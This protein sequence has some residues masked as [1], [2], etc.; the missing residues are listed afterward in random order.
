[1][2]ACLAERIN[3]PSSGDGTGTEMTAGESSRERLARRTGLAIRTIL[4]S[5]TRVSKMFGWL[6]KKSKSSI[7]VRLVIFEGR[8]TSSFLRGKERAFV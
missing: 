8:A 7:E 2:L 3:S 1:M 4:T 5:T 6:W